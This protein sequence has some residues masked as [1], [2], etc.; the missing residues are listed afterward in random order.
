MRIVLAS[1]SP[2]RREL[3]DQIGLSF[4]IIVSDVNEDV[5]A[6]DPAVMVEEL[7]ARKASAVAEQLPDE[8]DIL[9][10]GAD[11]LVAAG[12]AVLGK[13]KD[14]EDAVNML[15]MLE[16]DVHRVLTGVTLIARKNGREERKTF[17]ESTEVEFFPMSDEEILSYVA[18]NDPMDKA[19]SYAIQTICA[20]YIKGI[21]G[22]YN[23]VVGLPVGRL[24]Q[25]A[26][27]YLS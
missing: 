13:P 17:H 1:Q 23:N 8:E 14:T 21:R 18:T 27:E 12:N 6:E 25:E 7:S 5:A 4:D 11:T 3:L 9:I 19:G 10:I 2:R 16:G 15:H 26:K 24:Y 22:D 20:R